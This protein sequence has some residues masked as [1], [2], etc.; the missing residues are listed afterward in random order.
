MG[1]TG[2]HN[3]EWR[4]R[5]CDTID[6]QGRGVFQYGADA[7]PA[8][9][10]IVPHT[11]TLVFNLLLGKEPAVRVEHSQVTLHQNRLATSRGILLSGLA[12]PADAMS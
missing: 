1:V 8:R 9:N 12:R 10:T 11:N 6:T 7:L 5:F 4:K 3:V 2:V